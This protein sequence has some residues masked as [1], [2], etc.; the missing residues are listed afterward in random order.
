[1]ASI[2]IIFGASQIAQIVKEPAYS[3]GDLGLIPRSGRSFREFL[4]GESHGQRNLVGYRLWGQKESDTIEQLTHTH[5][6]THIIKE[7]A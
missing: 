3:A 2:F 5:T 7:A 6:H 4:P 1:M